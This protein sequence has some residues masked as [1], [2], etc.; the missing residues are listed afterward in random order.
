ML[1]EERTKDQVSPADGVVDQKFL[2]LLREPYE[3]VLG[4][5]SLTV[6]IDGT[7]AI[8]QHFTIIAAK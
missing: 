6:A 1:R 7:T 3:V 8:E 2:Y 4:D 5:W